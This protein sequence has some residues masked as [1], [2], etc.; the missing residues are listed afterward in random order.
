MGIGV[1]SRIMMLGLISNIAD[2]K[3]KIITFLRMKAK[4]HLFEGQDN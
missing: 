2:L 3:L 4:K 1:Y